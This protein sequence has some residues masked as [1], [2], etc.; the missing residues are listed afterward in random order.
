MS[1]GLSV[2][3]MNEEKNYKP[4]KMNAIDA[5]ETLPVGRIVSACQVLLNASEGFGGTAKHCGSR[6]V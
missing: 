6:Q 1:I 2:Y 5:V 3:L 4:I